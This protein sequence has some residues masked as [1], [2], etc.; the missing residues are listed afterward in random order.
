[1]ESD[2]LKKIP[3]MSVIGCFLERLAR[4]QET[5]PI[6]PDEG[7]RETDGASY[8]EGKKKRRIPNFTLRRIYVKHEPVFLATPFWTTNAPNM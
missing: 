4:G 1:M 8:C 6:Y 2:Q 7:K 5:K 3:S